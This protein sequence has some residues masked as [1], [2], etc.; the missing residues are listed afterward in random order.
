M[1]D[2]LGSTGKGT[3]MFLHSTA[4][5]HLNRE[6]PQNVALGWLTQTSLVSFHPY[7]GRLEDLGKSARIILISKPLETAW[8]S[9]RKNQGTFWAVS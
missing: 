5:F 4:F 7:S 9:H 8:R 6:K 3:Y 2:V 1:V